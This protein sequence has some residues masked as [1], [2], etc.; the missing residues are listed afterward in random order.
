MALVE[1]YGEM[2]AEIGADRFDQWAT[3]LGI[4]SRLQVAPGVNPE[5]ATSRLGWALSTQN[6]L[7]NARVL[8]DEL[9]K[10]PYR[11]TLQDSAFASGAGWARVPTGAETCAFC[12]MLA[13]RGGVYHTREL[14]RLG[15]SGKKYHGDCDC[16]PVPILRS[17]ARMPDGYNPDGLYDQYRQAR[18]DADS[19]DPKQILSAMRE[20][21]D[22]N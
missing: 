11:S 7:G 18:K 12:L 6:Q 22:L 2:A 13:S 9:V 21:F 20:R 4:R 3:E 10:Q 16:Q 1:K 19:G 8:T 17:G 5:R 14:A 15:T